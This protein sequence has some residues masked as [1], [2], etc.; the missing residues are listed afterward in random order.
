MSKHKVFAFP[1]SEN[2]AQDQT[3]NKLVTPREFP[4]NDQTN[5]QGVRAV[6]VQ[7][8]LCHPCTTGCFALAWSWCWHELKT[9]SRTVFVVHSG[10]RYGSYDQGLRLVDGFLFVSFWI[11]W[12]TPS[13]I[14]LMVASVA[15]ITW[16]SEKWYMHTQRILRDTTSSH[17][18]LFSSRFKLDVDMS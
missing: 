4:R 8:P 16:I 9:S 2:L 6:D 18:G 5:S 1:G 14:T 10:E 3:I 7:G 17:I 13:G 12:S 15:W 11:P